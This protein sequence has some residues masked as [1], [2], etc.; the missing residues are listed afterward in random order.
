[1]KTITL[2]NL[3][4]EVAGAVSRKA[5]KEGISLAK[6]VIRLLEEAAGIRR[7]TEV[8]HHDLDSLAGSWTPAQA[9]TFEKALRE[10]RKV[11]PELWK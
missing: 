1:M 9:A 6:A 4:K 2:R 11:D 5:R 7:K 8:L 3:P 10:Q